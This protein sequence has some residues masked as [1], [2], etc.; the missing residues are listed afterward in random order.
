MSAFENIFDNP[1]VLIRNALVTLLIPLF[2]ESTGNNP[3][4]AR[5]AAQELLAS[6]GARSPME[7][8][9]TA[10]SFAFGTAALVAITQ[11]IPEDASPSLAL[12]IRA[13]ANALNRSAE[14]CRVVVEQSVARP[15]PR[16]LDPQEEE[17]LLAETARV[18]AMT[19]GRTAPQP[20]TAK[21]APNPPQ[22]TPAPA[23]VAARSVSAQ[24]TAPQP[25]APQRTPAAARPVAPASMM[26]PP[27]PPMLALPSRAVS[28]AE[29]AA[30]KAA[31]ASAMAD[32]AQEMSAELDSLPPDQRYEAT[33]KIRSLTETAQELHTAPRR[34]G[35]RSAVSRPAGSTRAGGNW[36]HRQKT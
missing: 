22:A 23:P 6:Y 24:P 29:D 32:V 13:N 7:W 27:V 2:L 19:S 11:P 36:T 16:Q 5:L 14:R 1:G 33:L 17:A 35:G 30:Y 31:W 10:L 4:Y 21:P 9:F 8:L 34:Y 15:R 3:Q 20:P 12:R 18:V 25:T 26:Q 28:P